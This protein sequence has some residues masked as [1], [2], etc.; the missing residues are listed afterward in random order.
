[1]HTDLH[2]S[3]QE[4]HDVGLNQIVILPFPRDPRSIAFDLAFIRRYP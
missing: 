2:G 1:M 4:N 3:T